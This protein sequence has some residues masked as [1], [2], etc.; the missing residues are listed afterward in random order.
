MKWELVQ[1]TVAAN[2]NHGYQTGPCEPF[3]GTTAEARTEIERRATE[4]G[5]RYFACQMNGRPGMRHLRTPGGIY[6]TS[7]AGRI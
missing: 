4:T 2:G 6:I 3:E 7:T 1:V 5:L